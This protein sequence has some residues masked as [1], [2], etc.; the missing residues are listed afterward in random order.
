MN[1]YVC[2]CTKFSYYMIIILPKKCLFERCLK[3]NRKCNNILQ[4]L[5]VN[6]RCYNV[7]YYMDVRFRYIDMSIYQK[8]EII[9]WYGGRK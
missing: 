2:V 8:K 5:I 1:V 6:V 7:H 9:W 4:M 3:C